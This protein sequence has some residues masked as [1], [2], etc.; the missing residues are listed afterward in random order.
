MSERQGVARRS[1]L[2][3]VALSL[4]APYVVTSNALGAEGKRPASDRVTVGAIGVGGRG[5]GLLGMHND[6][7]CT[8]AAVCDVY[9]PHLSRAQKRIGGKCYA[10]TDFRRVLEHKD[11]DAVFIATP[12]HWHALITTMACKAGKDVYCEKPLSRTVV[13][14]REMVDVARKYRRIVQMGTQHRSRAVMRQVCEWVRNGRIGKVHKARLWM[15]RNSTSKVEPSREPP[16]GLDWDL[17]LGPAPWAA[18]HPKRCL[19]TFRFFMD[20]AGGRITDWG[21]HMF[22]VVS[23]A[24]GTDETGP[25][26][27]EGTGRADPESMYTV[28]VEM[29]I[30]YEFADP[31]FELTWEQPGDGAKGAHSFGMQFVGTEATITEYFGRHTVDRGEADL[32]PTKP[33][34]FH[35]YESSNHHGNWLECIA[36]RRLPVVDVEIGHRVTAWCH[37]G[38]IAYVLGRKLNWDPAQE[39]FVGD[40]E[41]NRLRHKAYREPWCL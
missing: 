25:V 7:R 2:A 22:S 36:A 33:D 28:P 9:Q 38:N 35:L 13:E 34:E 11:I 40:E 26:A 6:P 24:M 4:G 8:I 1:F 27:I 10:Y 17:W 37:L 3:H 18:Y 19:Y 14:G 12:D 31:P 20:Y 16:A 23:W 15:G 21:A 29:S 5:T 39:R 41:A 30:R 32:S